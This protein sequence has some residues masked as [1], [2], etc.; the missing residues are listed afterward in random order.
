MTI[1]VYGKPQCTDWARSRSLLE[2][3]KLKFEFHDILGDPQAAQTAQ[4]ISGGPASPVIVFEDRS[5]LVEP[6]DEDLT[7]SLASRGLV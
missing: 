4:E 1:T 7:E 2:A 5:F 6:S 3:H